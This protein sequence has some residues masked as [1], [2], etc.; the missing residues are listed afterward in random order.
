MDSNPKT[1]QSLD[2]P[3]DLDIEEWEYLARLGKKMEGLTIRQLDARLRRCGIDLKIPPELLDSD[4][5]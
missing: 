3:Q 4:I 5:N 1:C 2:F